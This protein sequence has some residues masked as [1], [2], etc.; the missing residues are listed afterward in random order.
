M[1]G[2][3]YKNIVGNSELTL[4]DAWEAARMAGMEEDIIQ[5]RC[6]VIS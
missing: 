6:T 2:S 4:D 5:W 3:I 1:S